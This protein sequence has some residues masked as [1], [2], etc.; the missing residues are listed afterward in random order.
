MALLPVRFGEMT[1]P[2]FPEAREGTLPEPPLSYSEDPESAFYKMANDVYAASQ[3]LTDDQKAMAIILERRTWCDY[4]G[5]LD[6]HHA[7]SN[8]AKKAAGLIKPAL[9]M[10]WWAFVLNEARISVFETKY[11]YV[12]I[13]P[14]TYIQHTI[15]N[16]STWLPFINTPEHPEYI[17]AHAVISESASQALDAAFGD[18]GSF[19]DHTYDYMGLAPRT[20]QSFQAIATEAGNSRFFGGIHYQPSID[21]GIKEGKKVAENVMN[22]LGI[23]GIN[24]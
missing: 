4:S 9:P 6:E 24:K 19:T 8:Q 2:L 22:K 5:S 23:N 14:I 17:S 12:L 20:F 3:V 1:G 10:H 15:P 18:V 7:A 16:A 11:T 13:R 21:L